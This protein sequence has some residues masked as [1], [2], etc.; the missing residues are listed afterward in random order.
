MKQ[1]LGTVLHS[2]G[3]LL[4]DR[5]ALQFLWKGFGDWRL[6][7]KYTLI[8]A[9]LNVVNLCFVLQSRRVSGQVPP[10]GWNHVLLSN[11][12]ANT[13][14]VRARAGYLASLLSHG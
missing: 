11:P 12:S 1:S 7:N 10:R 2:Y 4:R 5:G 13:L 6:D 9:I 8:M 3:N 14:K